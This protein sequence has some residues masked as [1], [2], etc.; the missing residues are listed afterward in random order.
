MILGNHLFQFGLRH[1]R[2]QFSFANVVSLPIN[3]LLCSTRDSSDGKR[4]RGCKVASLCQRVLVKRRRGKNELS[5]SKLMVCESWIFLYKVSERILHWLTKKAES[6]EKNHQEHFLSQ[7]SLDKQVFVRLIPPPSSSS[8]LF[9][10]S[11]HIYLRRAAILQESRRY[12][13]VFCVSFTHR[14]SDAMPFCPRSGGFRLTQFNF[15]LCGGP[16][17]SL[18]LPSAEMEKFTEM[19]RR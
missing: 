1:L 16:F 3:M 13:T 8:N 17:F 4:R 19:A 2:M 15:V 12:R 18:S 11:K 10:F 5:W 7:F 14:S 9:S 6:K